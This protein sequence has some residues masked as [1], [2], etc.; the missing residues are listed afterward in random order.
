MGRLIKAFFEKYKG[1]RRLSVLSAIFIL[2]LISITVSFGIAPISEYSASVL[3][4]VITAC[5][6]LIGLYKWL[7]ATEDKN[8]DK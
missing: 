3:N 8:K 4:S 7:R 6:V 5:G 1:V 2:L